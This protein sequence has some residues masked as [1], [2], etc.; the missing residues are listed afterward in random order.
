MEQHLFLLVGNFD[1]TACVM[2]SLGRLHNIL[3][4]DQDNKQQTTDRYTEFRLSD[5]RLIT[6]YTPSGS[7][8]S[9]LVTEVAAGYRGKPECE[10]L[11]CISLYQLPTSKMSLISLVTVVSTAPTFNM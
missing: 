3:C 6:L 11:I 5:T 4:S 8:Q 7:F 9:L 10:T 2:C 1:L